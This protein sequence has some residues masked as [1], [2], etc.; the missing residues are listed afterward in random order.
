MEEEKEEL[1]KKTT[2]TRKKEH[3]KL[4]VGNRQDSKETHP[5]DL[6]KRHPHII[7]HIHDFTL[8]HITEAFLMQNI[9]LKDEED[10]VH[11]DENINTVRLTQ[12][13]LNFFADMH[14]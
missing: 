4:K 3:L 8:D 12:L 14:C 7:R 9:Q 13:Q 2:N 10:L 1:P 6:T 5:F 11:G